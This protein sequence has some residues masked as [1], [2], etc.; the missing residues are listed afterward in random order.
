MSFWMTP[1]SS[2]P[3]DYLAED[4]IVSFSHPKV[5]ELAE[6][7]KRESKFLTAKAMFEYVRD[8]IPHTLD[9]GARAV[10]VTAGEVLELGH[11]LCFAKSHL[12]AA[13]LRS[14]GIPTGFCYQKLV[15]DDE[16]APWFTLHGLIAIDLSGENRWARLDARGNKP[17]VNAQFDL[18]SEKLAFPV[19][20][21][22]GEKDYRLVCRRPAPVV[23]RSMRATHS[24]NELLKKMPSQLNL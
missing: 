20:P 16:K 4:E 9:I 23:I 15:L 22:K 10:A 19:R 11:G 12:L 13:L 18:L 1:E 7:L 14:A 21:Q 5:R 6:S 3:A 8:D 17:G 2:D 24:V